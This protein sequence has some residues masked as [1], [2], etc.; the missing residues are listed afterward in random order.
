MELKEN[1]TLKIDTPDGKSYKVLTSAE[2]DEK[3]WKLK[4]IREEEMTDAEMKHARW[5]K[6]RGS[7]LLFETIPERK[8]ANTKKLG[9]G[10]K[11]GGMALLHKWRRLRRW[12]K[13]HERKGGKS[14][15]DPA[16]C[17]AGPAAVPEC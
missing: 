9:Q 5:P 8:L 4:Y 6:E 13:S 10:L 14:T 1:A 16:D 2:D 7:H 12:R 17:M 3:W 11:E 15:S